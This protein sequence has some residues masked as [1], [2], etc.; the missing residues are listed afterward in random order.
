[1]KDYQYSDS[2]RSSPQP[3]IYYRQMYKRESRL[4]EKQT[5]QND[6]TEEMHRLSKI[7]PNGRR[8]SRRMISMLLRVFFV[9]TAAYAIFALYLPIPGR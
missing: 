8:Y 1:M 7:H 9:S 3:D 5:L 2:V 4:R 6:M